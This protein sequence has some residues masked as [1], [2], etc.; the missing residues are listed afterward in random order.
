M[1]MEISI[2]FATTTITSLCASR[3]HKSFALET[4]TQPPCKE[5]ST[6]ATKRHSPWR[7]PNMR[8][9]AARRNADLRPV[10]AVKSLLVAMIRLLKQPNRGFCGDSKCLRHSKADIY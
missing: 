3:S 4:K 6:M 10:G 8:H 7:K 5:W 9:A 1:R 2:P